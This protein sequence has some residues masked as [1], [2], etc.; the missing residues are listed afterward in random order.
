[1]RV[2][3]SSTLVQACDRPEAKVLGRRREINEYLRE[4]RSQEREKYNETLCPTERSTSCEFWSN[5]PFEKKN[6]KIAEGPKGG[7]GR[8]GEEQQHRGEETREKGWEE[9][10]D[11]HM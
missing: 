6:K 11:K 9:Q 10:Q 4:A 7:H 5:G 1:M 2:L 3:L 8:G